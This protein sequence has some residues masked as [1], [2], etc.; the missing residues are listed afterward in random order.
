MLAL[1]SIA[2]VT[3]LQAILDQQDKASGERRVREEGFFTLFLTKGEVHPA[4]L[5]FLFSPIN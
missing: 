3:F 2:C 1:E 5:N 4:A